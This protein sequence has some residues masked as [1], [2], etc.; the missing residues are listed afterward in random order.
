M[1]FEKLRVYHAAQQL[2]KIVFGMIE[3]IASPGRLRSLIDDLNRALA[4]ITSN[5]AEAYGSDT[6]G[7]K[8]YHLSVARGST[9]EVRAKLQTLV[10]R[11]AFNAVEIV[12]PSILARTIAKMLTSWIDRLKDDAG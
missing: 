6:P 3:K 8:V 11:K 10:N 2:D 9:D 4:S 7:R 1:S 5:I 12:K